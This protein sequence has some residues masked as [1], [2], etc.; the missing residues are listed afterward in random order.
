MSRPAFFAVPAELAD[1]VPAP[2]TIYT[3]PGRWR[4]GKWWPPVHRTVRE[5]CAICVGREGR[6]RPDL[7]PHEWVVVAFFD[8][9]AAGFRLFERLDA[10]RGRAIVLLEDDSVKLVHAETGAIL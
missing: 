6:R 1:R 2:R 7:P 8:D 4:R 9:R 3:V 5:A 10:R